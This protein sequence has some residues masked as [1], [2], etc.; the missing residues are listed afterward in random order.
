M[1]RIKVFYGSAANSVGHWR[2]VLLVPAGDGEILGR[3]HLWGDHI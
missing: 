1:A 3:F 2:S